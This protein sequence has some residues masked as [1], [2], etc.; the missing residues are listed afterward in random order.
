MKKRIFAFCAATLM[1]LSMVSCGTNSKLVGKW[2]GDSIL[3]QSVG[4]IEFQSDQT[5]SL[6]FGKFSG[7]FTY[8]IDEANIHIF[9]L[10]D[11]GSAVVNES[12]AQNHMELPYL[13]TENG[14]VLTLTIEG[15]S[16]NFKKAD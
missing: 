4:W 8:E 1:L 14:T 2:V 15:R 7:K 6:S 9:P 10:D 3:G 16:M 13:T 5:G 11:A 12:G